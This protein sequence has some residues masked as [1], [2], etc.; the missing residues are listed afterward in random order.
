MLIPGLGTFVHEVT[1]LAAQSAAVV[2]LV[3]VEKAVVGIHRLCVP[4]GF[5]GFGLG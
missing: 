2:V 4:F 5:G 1:T 3:V